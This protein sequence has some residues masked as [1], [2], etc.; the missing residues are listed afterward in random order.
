M[1]R[2]LLLLALLPVASFG[3]NGRWDRQASTVQA[4]GGNLLPIFAI[5]GANVSFYSCTSNVA[6]SCTIPAVTYNGAGAAC[7]STAQVNPQGSLACTGQADSAGNFGAW[8]GSGAYAYT[9]TAYGTSYGPYMFSVGGGS[10]TSGITSINGAIGPAMTIACGS[11]LTCVT[12]GNT[13]TITPIGT[14]N[15]TSF[16][17]GKTVELG[18]VVT[19]PTFNATYT[20]TPASAS[21][22]NTE[23]IGSPLVL[24]SPFTTGTVSGTFVHTATTTTTFTLTAT[25]GTTQSAQQT[26]A[27]QPAIFGGPGTGGATSSV[28]ASGT[29]AVLSTGSVLPRVQLGAE[30]V[31]QTFGPYTASS[32]VIYLLLMGSSHTFIDANTGFPFA[33]NAP[34]AVSFTNA[35]GTV[36]T[37]YLSSSTNVLTGSFAP[38]VAS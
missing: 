8:F 32:Q 22:T 24:S 6:S 13:I 33:F 25:Q 36:V 17:G 31:G 19:N 34:V 38:K 9:L 21:I 5:P 1:K 26:I 3:Q 4:Q 18:T 12:S 7:P 30:T 2:L 29:T 11:G 35:Q 15:I 27:W 16:T 14:F 23:S 28:T 37:M 10:G 20:I